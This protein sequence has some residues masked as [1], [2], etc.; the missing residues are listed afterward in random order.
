MRVR[1]MRWVAMTASVATGVVGATLFSRSNDSTATELMYS[2]EAQSVEEKVG[3]NISPKP[4]SPHV[5]TSVELIGV[6]ASHL[7]DGRT[8]F[9]DS[10]RKGL[11]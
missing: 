5:R 9:Q 11:N 6:K 8:R 7:L 3:V 2:S 10:S 1:Y 4:V